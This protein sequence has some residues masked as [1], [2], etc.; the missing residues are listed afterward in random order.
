MLSRLCTTF[1]KRLF[2]GAS[3]FATQA[4]IPTTKYDEKISKARV[5]A[6]LY[7]LQFY[8]EDANFIAPNAT[9]VGEVTIG[10]E[11][12]I[13]GGTV[14]R[15]DI[16]EV[17]YDIAYAASLRRSTLEKTVC[18]SLRRVCPAVY[19]PT[20]PWTITWRCSRAAL[21]TPAKSAERSL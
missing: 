18:C 15:G 13:W 12:C 7:D 6:Q 2:V 16:N 11:V 9:I 3:R 10:S 8:E 1:S 14:I 17:V 19:P 5:I 4:V 20:S 21:S